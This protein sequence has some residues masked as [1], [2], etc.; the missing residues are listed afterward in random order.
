M[1]DTE[2]M[3]ESASSTSWDDFVTIRQ[4]LPLFDFLGERIEF[5]SPEEADS[6]MEAYLEQ[7]QFVLNTITGAGED[8]ATLVD[9]KS[10]SVF[11]E[12][13]TAQLDNILNDLEMFRLLYRVLAPAGD[14]YVATSIHEARKW[15]AE[16]FILAKE[17][18]SGT[19]VVLD[20]VRY[21]DGAKPVVFHPWH[22]LNGDVD[23]KVYRNDY[24]LPV[25]G[26]ILQNPGVYESNVAEKFNLFRSAITLRLVDDLLDMGVIRA[27]HFRTGAVDSFAALLSGPRLTEPC[28]EEEYLQH[29]MMRAQNNVKYERCLFP[30]VDFFSKLGSE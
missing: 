13:I 21:V 10:K 25:A 29:R 11:S 5:Q 28:S 23:L 30:V 16:P 22:K 4:T 1:T 3:A 6:A 20:R 9:F 26:Y 7:C 24:L 18:I 17:V 19:S 8:G 2:F 12:E 14:T 15:V 27:T